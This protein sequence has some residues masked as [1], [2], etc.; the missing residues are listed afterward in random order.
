VVL[1]VDDE[2]ITLS[3]GFAP[4]GVYDVLL[5]D[6]HVWSLQP[7]RDTRRSD[8]RAHARWPKALRAYLRG[9]A[10]VALRDHAGDQVVAVVDHVFGGDADAE[11]DVTDK[12]GH[13]LIL[14]KWGRLIR[15][16][17]AEDHGVIDE[18]METVVRLLDD[19][20][21]KAGVPAFICYGTLLG[22]V[23]NG[24]MI[25]HDNDVDLAYVSEHPHPVDVIREAYRV[26][27]ALLDAGWVVR[28]GSGA[29]INVRLR[30]SDRSWRFV[31][32][33]TANW[34]EGILYIPSDTGFALPQEVVLPL[35]PLVLHGREVPGPADPERLLV[36]TY[37]ESWRV[38]DPSFKYETPRWLARRFGGWFGGLKTQR[39]HWDAFYGYGAPGVP[40]KPS[41]FARWVARSYPS[42]R[43][44]VDLGAGNG[45]DAIF[46]A[47]RRGRRVTALDYSLHAVGITRRRARRRGASLSA[48]PLNLYDLRE[49]LS[50]GLRLSRTPAPVDLYARF[51]MH[52]LD[53]VGR[54]NVLRL[55][56]M[57]LRR[58]GL[59]F[60]EFRTGQDAQRP[61][62][63]GEHRRYYLAPA[64]VVKQIEAAGGRVVAQEQ[65]TGLA[66]LKGED[67]YVCRIVASWSDQSA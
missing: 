40:R 42:D 6:R 27:R 8:D 34:V 49:V 51:T 59:L 66:P 63:F 32:V 35:K 39:K 41:P 19:L 13:D 43:P 45:R 21:D 44:I 22:A 18:L 58:G 55:A 64:T 36:A 2:R 28:R 30:M 54:R 33:F 26:E 47:L 67:P 5:N 46:F 38:P 20:R 10:T 29:R 37:G 3:G 1:E 24:R 56:S 48:A 61:H 9:H 12:D 50:F 31:D 23:R 17:S 57:A 25:G 53:H 52:A 65:G 7:A 16:L 11:V 62:V 15:P 4:E 60:L 14:D